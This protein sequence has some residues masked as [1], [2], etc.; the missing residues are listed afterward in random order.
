MTSCFDY[1]QAFLNPSGIAWPFF[2]F[3]DK[4]LQSDVTNH[5]PDRQNMEFAPGNGLAV[6]DSCEAIAAQAINLSNAGDDALLYLYES[7]MESLA[8]Q[9]IINPTMISNGQEAATDICGPSLGVDYGERVVFPVPKSTG[10]KEIMGCN[11]NNLV[12]HTRD[13]GKNWLR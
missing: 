10:R 11:A 7:T 5:L 3:E 8:L 12:S 9:E 4:K 13:D 1:Y 2:D 6:S